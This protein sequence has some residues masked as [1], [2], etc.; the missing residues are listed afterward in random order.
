MQYALMWHLDYSDINNS[1]AQNRG[2]F[3]SKPEDNVVS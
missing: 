3:N 1:N 2:S